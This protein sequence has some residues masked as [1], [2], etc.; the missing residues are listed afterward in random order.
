MEHSDALG[1]KNNTES[2]EEEFARK[3]AELE[4]KRQEYYKKR[5]ERHHRARD[6]EHLTVYKAKTAVKSRPEKKLRGEGALRRTLR[7][8]RGLRETRLMMRGKPWYTAERR[9][10]A[11]GEVFRDAWQPLCGAI[12]NAVDTGWDFLCRLAE[13]CRGR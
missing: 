7:L 13:G 12:G 11:Y 1:K 6:E 5:G 3:T 4:K 8:I 10:A 9:R 2:F